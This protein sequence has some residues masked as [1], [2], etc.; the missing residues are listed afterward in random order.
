MTLPEFGSWLRYGFTVLTVVTI[1][2][3]LLFWLVVHP[4]APRLQKLGPAKSYGILTPA[5]L[6][7]GFGLFQIRGLLV[8]ADLGWSPLL[9]AVGVVF[10]ATSARV[11]LRLRRHLKFRTLAGVPEI[12]GESGNLLT[13]GIYGQI[14]HPRYLAF[15]LGL[16]GF[17][18]MVNYLGLYVMV[19]LTIPALAAVVHLE[20]RELEQRFGEEYVR[21]RNEVPAVVP[22]DRGFL[23]EPRDPEGGGERDA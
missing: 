17:A 15:G 5:L 6:L 20:D 8:G 19:A 9:F 10:Y 7:V 21:Y 22:R 12:R 16:L 23:R 3:A 14:R 11:E 1:P 4:L 2:P 13:E 18:F